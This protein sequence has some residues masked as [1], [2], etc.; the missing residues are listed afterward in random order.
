M[1]DRAVSRFDLV[2]PG[3][4]V[5]NARA[6][7]GAHGFYTPKRTSE[8]RE[9]VQAAWLLAG[10]PSLGSQ[11]FAV[12]AQFYRFSRRAADLDN[13]VKGVLDALNGLAFV[14]D[15]QLVCLAGVHKLSCARGDDRTE[16]SLWVAESERSR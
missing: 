11:A 15:A 1:S 14:D 16:L 5:P 4:P 13:L 3:E 2:V 8:Y 6:R 9:R 12:S 7:R 10:R